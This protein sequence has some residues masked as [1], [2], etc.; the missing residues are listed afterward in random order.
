MFPDS[1]SCKSVKEVNKFLSFSC[2]P[3]KGYIE[4]FYKINGGISSGNI[5]L[6][7]IDDKYVIR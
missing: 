6:G 1:Q 4:V 3:G 2:A 7:F 5:S